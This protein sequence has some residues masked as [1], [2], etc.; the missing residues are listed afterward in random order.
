[1]RL[2]FKHRKPETRQV[3]S[4]FF[5]VDP[6]Q[7]W[8]AGQ[9][10]KMTFAE[11][12]SET[13]RRFTISSAPSEGLIRVTTKNSGSDFKNELF[14]LKPGD[15]VSASAINGDFIWHETDLPVVFLAAGIGITPYR[16]ILA[17]RLIENKKIPVTLIYGCSNPEE[18]VFKEELDNW[19]NSHSEFKIVYEQGRL[20]GEF[21]SQHCDLK[22]SLVY[23]SGPGAM[24]DDIFEDLTQ[25]YHTPQKNII[26]DWF[27]G[28]D[29]KYPMH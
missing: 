19:Q 28:L 14:K 5:D 21:I 25:K 22:N 12:F 13:E 9:S 15:I 17:Q 24:V 20:S 11:L 1:M 29:S 16:S 4:Y 18:F 8:T 3:F 10:L 6:Q 27:V 23:I 7:N 26:R 2:K